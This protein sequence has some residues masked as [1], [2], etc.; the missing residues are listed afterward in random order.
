MDLDPARLRTRQEYRERILRVLV[1][2][3]HHLDEPLHLE[4]LAE[5]AGY[6][7][8]YF[9]RLF[10]GLVGETVA[11]HVRRVRLE[12]AALALRHPAPAIVRIALDA[13]YQD[14]SAFTRAFR[15]RFGC[16]PS[17][18]RRRPRACPPPDDLD[19]RI[20]TQLRGAPTMDIAIRTLDPMRV[21]FIRHIGP[22]QECAPAWA[23]LVAW[24][25]PRGLLTATATCLGVGHDD[26][27]V[28]APE[29]IRYDACIVIPDGTSVDGGVGIQVLP[30]GEHAVT[31]HRGPYDLLPQVYLEVIGRWLPQHG[32]RVGRGSPYE[33]Y[34][35]DVR[36]TP[37]QDLITEIRVPLA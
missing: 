11:D 30:G 9:H 1:H 32:R 29:R 15:T 4:R 20:D 27:A 18:W 37:A 25:S 6:S 19:R 26:P 24:A 31:V 35:N 36:S 5:L 33:I 28:T 21:A 34:R 7:P 12:R 10:T 3:Q 13:G 16:S 17:A 22:Y 8:C 14:H 23:A 2:L